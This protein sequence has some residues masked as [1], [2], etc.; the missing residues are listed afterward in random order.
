MAD[1]KF[2]EREDALCLED[3][4]PNRQGCKDVVCRE[5][6]SSLNTKSVGRLYNTCMATMS[7]TSETI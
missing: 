2:E 7:S 5:T 1:R 6:V 3:V 4:F